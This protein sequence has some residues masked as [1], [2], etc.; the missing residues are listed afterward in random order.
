MC[1]PS[2]ST[3][4]C[5]FPFPLTN[6]VSL[7]LPVFCCSTISR[8]KQNA[9]F[10]LTR[11]RFFEAPAWQARPLPRHEPCDRAHTHQHERSDRARAPEHERSNVRYPRTSLATVRYSPATPQRWYTPTPY[12]TQPSPRP[13]IPIG[14][15]NF[16][17]PALF[18]IPIG[19]V[20]V[21]FDERERRI[22]N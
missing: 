11:L 22:S 9:Y 18:C 7:F 1:A 16:L 19:M 20:N 15:L 10:A 2:Y 5:F 12:S 21:I 14:V 4:L 8:V 13:R 17:I 3:Y 6:S